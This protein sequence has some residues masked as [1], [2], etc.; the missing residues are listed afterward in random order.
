MKLE[1]MNLEDKMTSI[2]VDH[3]IC[4]IERTIAL[5]VLSKLQRENASMEL[6]LKPSTSSK[7]QLNSDTQLDSSIV[8]FEDSSYTTAKQIIDKLLSEVD[9][10]DKNLFKLLQKLQVIHEERSKVFGSNNAL[11]TML[12]TKDSGSQKFEVEVQDSIDSLG[13][14]KSILPYLSL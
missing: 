14:E 6:L 12:E 1:K 13:A 2:R 8:S 10:R 3:K 5:V 7:E 4:Q 11:R 9:E